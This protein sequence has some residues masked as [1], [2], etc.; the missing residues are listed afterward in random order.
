MICRNCGKM[1]LPNAGHIIDGKFYCNECVIECANCGDYILKD[2]AI[3][4]H[5]GDLICENCKEN[6]YYICEDC[7]E[8]Y[9]VDDSHWIEDKEK[10]VCD[11]CLDNYYECECCQKYFSRADVY[12]TYDENWVCNDCYVNS[13][14]SCEDCGCAVSDN[15][16]YYNEGHGCNYCPNCSDNHSDS[17]Y[18][19]HDYS[20]FYKYKKDDEINPIEYFG[21]E[22]EVSGNECY[23]D[24]FLSKVPNVV[25]MHDSSIEDGGF[26]IVSEPMTRRYIEEDFLPLLEKGMKYLNNNGFTGHNR[27]GIHIHVSQEVFTKRMLCVLR[28]VLYSGNEENFDIWKVISQ[29][30]TSEIE[31]WCR[32]TEGKN[33]SEILDSEDNYP[34]ISDTRY[35]ALNYDSRTGTY[36]FR[37]FNSNTRIE[38]IKKNI[39]VVYS[40]IDYAKAKENK[41]IWAETE[42]Y[43][44][45]V[46]RDSEAYPDLYKFLYDMGIVQRLEEER[47]AA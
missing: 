25:L 26:E 13:Y 27:G 1:I 24:A 43:I 32:F 30:H 35:T 31:Q 11:K 19:Y 17:I 38:R 3:E 2:D 21:L 5:D 42:D 46:L 37:I 18:S 36:E 12:A 40:L 34:P 4:T 44:D 47:M 28:N 7:G 29:R 45:F 33:C 10:Y 6:D 41:Y 9:H 16:Y 14:C 20:D 8:V 15:D 39:Q 22:I 23:A